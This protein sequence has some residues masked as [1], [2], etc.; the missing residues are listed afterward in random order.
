MNQCGNCLDG[1]LLMAG[2]TCGICGNHEPPKR[3]P[4][5]ERQCVYC[6]CTD[7]RACPGGCGW[8]VRHP[9]T[10]TG[11]CSACVDRLPGIVLG[12]ISI[13]PPRAGLVWMQ[14]VNGPNAGDGMQTEAGVLAKAVEKF[15]RK[16][17]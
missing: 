8:A 16:H 3:K 9:K 7:S 15:Y 13:T 14:V 12:Q 2:E 11:V 1:K 5:R 6:G 10:L 4:K 17:F